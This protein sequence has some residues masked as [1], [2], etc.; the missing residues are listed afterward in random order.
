MKTQKIKALAQDKG[1]KSAMDLAKRAGIN[2]N[3]AQKIW[4]MEEVPDMLVSTITKIVGALGSSYRDLLDDEEDTPPTPIT[5][6]QE[7]PA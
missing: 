1:C 6:Y 5:E 3:L 2:L 7:I 4:R